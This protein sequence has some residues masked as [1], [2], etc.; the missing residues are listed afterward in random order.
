MVNIKKK[1][2]EVVKFRASKS[3]GVEKAQAIANFQKSEEF[4]ALY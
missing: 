4:F 2:A 3:F 1:A